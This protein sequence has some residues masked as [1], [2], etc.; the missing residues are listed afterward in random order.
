LLLKSGVNG[1]PTDKR[2]CRAL[3]VY[4]KRLPHPLTPSQKHFLNVYISPYGDKAVQINFFR[5][6]LST[7]GQRINEYAPV[8]L[9]RLFVSYSLT[10]GFGKRLFWRTIVAAPEWRCDAHLGVDR[11]QL[12]AQLAQVSDGH[13]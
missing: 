10:A 13:T 2:I 8:P 1:L 11:L 7:N 12:L 6:T 5:V 9:I 4:A 3:S